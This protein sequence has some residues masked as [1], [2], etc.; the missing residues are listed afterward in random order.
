MKPKYPTLPSGKVSASITTLK[1][2]DFTAIPPPLIFVSPG[3]KVSEREFA[4]NSPK[5]WPLRL[6][7]HKQPALDEEGRGAGHPDSC[8]FLV[9]G[10]RI[11]AALALAS[12]STSVQTLAAALPNTL[13]WSTR[14]RRHR[15]EGLDDPEIYR[16]GV[17][18]TNS[19]DPTYFWAKWRRCLH[20]PPQEKRSAGDLSGRCQGQPERNFRHC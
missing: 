16:I 20:I 2:Y 1:V 12:G 19:A 11:K 6:G 8:A 5:S 15:P 18:A 10:V 7:V 17:A 13:R 3:E 9:T 4:V 14:S